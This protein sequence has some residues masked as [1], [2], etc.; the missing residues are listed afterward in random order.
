MTITLQ[1]SGKHALTYTVINGQP[2]ACSVARRQHHLHADA[3]FQ[4]RDSLAFRVNDG[5]F[6][7]NLAKV[8]INVW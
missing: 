5:Q 6:N 1:G 7:S 4:Q 2:T 3:Q 8:T